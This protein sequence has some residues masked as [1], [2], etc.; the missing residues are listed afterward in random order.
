[1]RVV[2]WLTSRVSAIIAHEQAD[3]GEYR[4][5]GGSR[6][7]RTPTMTSELEEAEAVVL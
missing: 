2:I 5:R 3:R 1:M 4:S 6:E 7:K